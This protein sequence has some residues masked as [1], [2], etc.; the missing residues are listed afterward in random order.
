MIRRAVLLCFVT[1]ALAVSPGLRAS[2][3]PTIG[4]DGVLHRVDVESWASSGRLQGTA[5]RH[6]LQRPDGTT[7]TVLVP[8]TEDAAVDRE[9]ALDADDRSGA[10]VL[11]WSR[12]EGT[13]LRLWTSRFQ[14][15]AWTAAAPLATGTSIPAAT[16]RVRVGGNLVHVV[17]WSPGDAG[18]SLWRTSYD[19]RSMA[20]VWG[21]ERL[22]APATQAVS[23]DGGVD[24]SESPEEADVF[25]AVYSSPLGS[26]E[27][28]R[29][30]IWGVRDEPVPIDYARALIIP[31]DA[32][33]PG[34]VEA[35]RIGTRLVAWYVTLDCLRYA[36]REPDG[37]WSS[38]R[39]VRLTTTTGVADAKLLVRDLV[40]RLEE[41]P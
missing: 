36:I 41:T 6:T 27:G 38:Q 30:T 2:A 18:G 11:V 22:D 21:P 33:N 26:G 12:L 16:P 37:T 29:V 3:S 7:A 8:G 32:K 5:L 15:G 17:W 28:G 19:T 20:L 1:F 39:R 9:P 25:F 34:D 31:E 14:S 13:T 10:V 24:R 23:A 4:L 40:R 35:S